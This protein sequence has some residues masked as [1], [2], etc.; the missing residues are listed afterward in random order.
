MWTLVI[1]QKTPKGN[2]RIDEEVVFESDSI[3]KLLNLVEYFSNVSPVFE[4]DYTIKKKEE[5]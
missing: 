2:Y 5:E 1:K 3:N 4:T